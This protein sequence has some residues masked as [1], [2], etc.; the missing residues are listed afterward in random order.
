MSR[1]IEQVRK[2]KAKVYGRCSNIAKVQSRNN[3]FNGSIFFIDA[4][5][6]VYLV[7]LSSRKICFWSDW[8]NIGDHDHKVFKIHILQNPG[9]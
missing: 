7:L 3:E 4:I 1:S 9:R 6:I 8:I 2:I 5:N